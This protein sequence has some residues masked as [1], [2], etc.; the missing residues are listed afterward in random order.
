MS[1]SKI[2]DA[3][4]EEASL[5]NPTEIITGL[6]AALYNAAVKGEIQP[7]KDKAE[8]LHLLLTPTKNTVLHI[9]IM[10]ITRESNGSLSYVENILKLNSLLLRQVNSF[11]DAPLHIAAR[12]GHFNM[13]RFLVQYAKS[14]YVEIDSEE[15]RARILLQMTNDGKDTALHEAVRYDHVYVVNF[16]LCED[17][18]FP[19]SSNAA[20]ETPLYLAAER[21]N[22][23]L[24]SHI[25]ELCTSPAHGGP[26]GRTALH[27]AVLY[28]NEGW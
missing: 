25:L 14:F 11:G 18:D 24:V 10:S 17:G 6:D 22:A 8:Q 4:R 21:G 5:G 28:N 26:N 16:L 27:A 2:E 15:E 19:Y 23:F 3:S 13:T 20:G 9:H 1:S 7:F 12:L